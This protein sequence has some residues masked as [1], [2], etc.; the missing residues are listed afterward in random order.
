MKKLLTFSLLSLGLCASALA[1]SPYELLG[2]SYTQNFDGLAGGLPAGWAVY[3]NATTTS[4]GTQL[5][6]NTATTPWDQGSGQFSNYAAKDTFYAAATAAAQNAS[7]NRA[8]GVKPDASI[9]TGTAVVFRI[10]NTKGLSSINFACNVMSLDLNAARYKYWYMDY[11]VGSNPTSFNTIAGSFLVGNNTFFQFP[12][13]VNLPSILNN[14]DSSVWIRIIS[15]VPSSN[16]LVYPTAAIDDVNITWVGKPPVTVTYDSTN[17]PC[18]GGLTGAINNIVADGGTPPYTYALDS[19]APNPPVFS[20]TTS[21]NSLPA[22]THYIYVKDSDGTIT[23]FP[24]MLTQPVMPLLTVAYQGKMVTCAGGSNGW[25]VAF[26]LIGSGTSPYQYSWDGGSYGAF[27]LTN[28]TAMNLNAGL[29]VVTIRDTN[30]CLSANNITITEPDSI[31]TYVWDQWN[32]N[33]WG[34]SSGEI[35]LWYAD[36][37]WGGYVPVWNTTPADTTWD[38]YNLPNGTYTVTTYDDSGCHTS[39]TYTISSPDPIVITPNITDDMGGCTGSVTVT[40]TGGV[41]NYYYEWSTGAQG[42][43]VQTISGLCDG[44]TYYLMVTDDNDCTVMD[45]ITIHGPTS[46]NNT[47]ATTTIKLYPNPVNDILYVDAAEAVNIRI[48]DLTGRAVLTAQ[49]AKQVSMANLANGVYIVNIMSSDNK[50]IATR[51][52]MK[53]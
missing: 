1:Q 52:I 14:Q 28:D 39:Q 48:E 33:C 27:K 2:H 30:G 37:G 26:A 32:N 5:T 19:V 10:K 21:Y 16:S 8:L 23:S 43:F 12:I 31:R 17:V 20:N 9:D 40:V 44:Q 46:V 49:N 45:T 24:V 25:G 36:G 50:L 4:L 18:Y 11:G 6:F 41:P 51:K 34:D 53:Q 7:P 42:S 38:I 35:E 13:S 15:Y 47:A 3:K 22:G 29:H